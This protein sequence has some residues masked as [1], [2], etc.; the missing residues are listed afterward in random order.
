M[1]NVMI[2]AG[3]SITHSGEY[4]NIISEK[5]PTSLVL[6]KGTN[7]YKVNDLEDEWDK[8]CIDYNPD[9]VTVLVGINEVI[10]TMRGVPDVEKHFRESYSRIIEKTRSRTEADIILMEPFVMAYPRK[11]FNWMLVTKR[12]VNIV[13]SL[14]EEYG[15]GL[16]KLWDVFNK[17][18]ASVLTI[19]GIHITPEGHRLISQAWLEEYR[20]MMSEKKKN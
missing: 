16:V 12:F 4:V 7:G 20:H 19:D 9:V 17:A 14:S 5:Y 2:F 3:D 1:S 18:D 8:I 15:T 6:N 10:D 11:L 13:D